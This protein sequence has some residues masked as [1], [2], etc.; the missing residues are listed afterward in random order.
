MPS[1]VADQLEWLAEAGLQ[2]R[3]VFADGDLAV[4]A[5]DRSP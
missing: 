3:V 2:P 1:T 5:A 4:I